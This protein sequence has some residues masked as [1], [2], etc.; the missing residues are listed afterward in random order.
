MWSVL[1][2]I[3]NTRGSSFDIRRDTRRQLTSR[4]ADPQDFCR[5]VKV[6]AINTGVGRPAATVS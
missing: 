3:W 6:V 5:S 2:T 1:Q 4:R